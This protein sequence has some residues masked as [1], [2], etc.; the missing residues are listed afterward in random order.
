MKRFLIAIALCIPML[1]V[2]DNV[3]A[4]KKNLKAT[5]LYENIKQKLSDMNAAKFTFTFSAAD[6]DQALLAKVDGMFIGEGNRFKLTTSAMEVYCDGEVKWIYNPVYKELIIF[7]HDAASTDIAE[8]P[9]AV[10]STADARSFDFTDKAERGFIDKQAVSIISMRPKDKNASYTSVR[11]AISDKNSLPASI[12]YTTI[13][14]DTYSVFILSA[15]EV[16]SSP[17]SFYAPSS[18]LLNDPDIYITDMR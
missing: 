10:L 14:G 1:C 13:N 18:E 11:I 17:A 16:P 9:F 15:T 6:R 3:S 5:E 12:E 8:N 4:Q 7:P 2:P